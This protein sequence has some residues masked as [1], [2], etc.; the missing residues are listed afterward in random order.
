MNDVM[1]GN[2]LLIYEVVIF[3]FI[4]LSGFF[5]GAET[6]LV[7][8]RRVSI[9][10]TA[11]KG[12]GNGRRALYLIDHL[13]DAMG[14]VLIGNNI[15]NIAA[16][17]FITYVATS[18]FMLREEQIFFVTAAQTMIFLLFCEITP[19]IVAKAKAENVLLFFSFPL[20]MLLVIFSPVNRVSLSFSSLVKRIFRIERGGNSIVRSRDELDILFQI[21]EHDGVIEE[22]HHMYVSEILSFKDMTAAEVMTHTIDIISVELKSSVRQLAELIESTRFSRIPVFEKRVDNIIGYVFYRDIL[23]RRDVKE[24]SELMYP[25]KYVPS[26]KNIFELFLEMQE[27]K[28]PLVFVVNEYGAVAGMVSHE[29]IAEEVVGEIQTIDHGDRELIV[30]T[31]DREYQLSGDLD[32]EHFERI[33]SIDIEKRGFE[34]IAGFIMYKLGRIPRKG[35]T[36]TYG[37]YSFTVEEVTERSIKKAVL[38]SRSRIK[39]NI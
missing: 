7:S 12:H 38:R 9:E 25:A 31:S 30:R 14:M 1:S 2:T 16:T 32:I 37:R 17:A 23:R 13:E 20:K 29:D 8:S 10:T 28:V 22:E 39:A 3:V 35:E 18:A 26:T 11:R 27:Q 21:G 19:K 34:T 4:L 24:I 33:F 5:S 15:V 6:A 36:V